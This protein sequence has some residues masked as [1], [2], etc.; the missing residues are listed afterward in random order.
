[1]PNQRQIW[2]G[3]S[4]KSESIVIIWPARALLPEQEQEPL[5]EQGLLPGQEQEQ[6]PQPEP[7][8]VRERSEPP[9]ALRL[10]QLF[11]RIFGSP[12]IKPS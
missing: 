4:P 6:A 2:S 12:P 10:P 11:L 9:P 7:E 3:I 1:M 5:P 8:P